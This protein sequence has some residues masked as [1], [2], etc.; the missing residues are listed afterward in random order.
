M[1]WCGSAVVPWAKRRCAALCARVLCFV[2]M[3]I[4]IDT[5]RHSDREYKFF[6][7]CAE[8]IIQKEIVVTPLSNCMSGMRD[9]SPVLM[10]KARS[11][12]RERK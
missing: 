4:T 8:I 12:E 5:T 7:F 3:Q 9:E 11:F 10:F 6:F 2:L 1:Q